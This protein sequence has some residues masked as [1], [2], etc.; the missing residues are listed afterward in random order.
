VVHHL[1]HHFHARVGA[2][3]SPFDQTEDVLGRL[4]PRTRNTQCMTQSIGGPDSSG[5]ESSRSNAS[6]RDLLFRARRSST[7][8]RMPAHAMSHN[9]AVLNDAPRRRSRA[10]A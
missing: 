8:S 1:L 3:P 5:W 10:P 6:L 2:K 7:A 4:T 9:S